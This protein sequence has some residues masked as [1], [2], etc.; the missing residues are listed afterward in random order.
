MSNGRESSHLL[1]LSQFVLVG[2]TNDFQFKIFMMI[3]LSS[4]TI[5]LLV[6]YYKS[7]KFPTENLKKS[8]Q[9]YFPILELKSN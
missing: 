8:K 3:P 5:F 4:N 9:T 7:L 6:I 2:P 1:V